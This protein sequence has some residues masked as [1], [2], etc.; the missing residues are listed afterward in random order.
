MGSGEKWEALANQSVKNYQ[1][2]SHDRNSYTHWLLADTET[3][4]C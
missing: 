1:I 4:H 3:I 2:V